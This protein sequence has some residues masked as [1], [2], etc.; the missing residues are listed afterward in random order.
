MKGPSVHVQAEAFPFGVDALAEPKLPGEGRQ[1]LPR[2]LGEARGLD[3]ALDQLE[4]PRKGVVTI[5]GERALSA[6]IR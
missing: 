3:G 1:F 6:D 2:S 4:L 5:D